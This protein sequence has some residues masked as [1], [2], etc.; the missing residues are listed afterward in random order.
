MRNVSDLHILCGDYFGS[1]FFFHF[2]KL[3]F[4]RACR[5]SVN[6]I[7]LLTLQVNDFI[8]SNYCRLNAFSVCIS[9]C[10]MTFFGSVLLNCKCAALADRGLTCFEDVILIYDWLWC[11]TLL[12]IFFALQ[13][14]IF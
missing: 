8:Y 1:C 4:L 13:V 2:V 9:K 5:Y 14:G 10:Q 3:I 7:A 11:V 6:L 12:I